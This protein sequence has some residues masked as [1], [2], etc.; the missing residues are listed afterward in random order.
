MD[1]FL[2]LGGEKK[3]IVETQK[4]ADHKKSDISS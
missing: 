2:L 3:P 1:E 4:S